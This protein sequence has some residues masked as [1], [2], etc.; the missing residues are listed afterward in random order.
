MPRLR[1][2]PAG[3]TLRNRGF[4]SPEK[5]LAAS[6]ATA[7]L[8]AEYDVARK[9]GQAVMPVILFSRLPLD[10]TSGRGVRYDGAGTLTLIVDSALQQNR[11]RNLSERLLESLISAGLP[12]LAVD[13]HIRGSRS[14]PPAQAPSEHVRTPSIIA[15]AELRD[16]ARTLSNAELREQILA[17]A[18]VLDPLPEE[19]PLAVSTALESTAERLAKLLERAKRLREQLPKAPDPQL[20]PDEAAAAADPELAALR[21]RMRARLARRTIAETE[22]AQTAAAARK[23]LESLRELSDTLLAADPAVPPPDEGTFRAA[24]ERAV[25]A[26]RLVLRLSRRFDAIEERLTLPLEE[27]AGSALSADSPEAAGTD[28]D[29]AEAGT[30]QQMTP[31]E[32]RAKLAKQVK[33]LRKSLQSTQALLLQARIRMPELPDILAADSQLAEEAAQLARKREAGAP[34][35]AL[36]AALSPESSRRLIAWESRLEI[37]QRMDEIEKDL[38][39]AAERFEADRPLLRAPRSRYA[40]EKPETLA[41]LQAI[42]RRLHEE[43]VLLSRLGAESE[44]LSERISI[45]RGDLP[46]V[47]LAGVSPAEKNAQETLERFAARLREL[48]QKLGPRI[49]EAIIPTEAEA[50][51][52]GELSALRAR[53]LARLARYD[54]RAALLAAAR[55]A[56][57]AIGK[58]LTEPRAEGMTERLTELL[59]KALAEAAQ[60]LEAARTAIA[61]EL[62][63]L[64][65]DPDAAQAAPDAAPAAPGAQESEP[66][67]P[68]LFDSMP[69]Q[70]AETE[71]A[72]EAQERDIR[73]NL[74]ALKDIFPIWLDR[75]PREPD[76][77]LIPDEA[78]CAKSET[79]RA[80]RSRMLAR[81]ERRRTLEARLNALK[82]AAS[83]LEERLSNPLSD[84]AENEALAGRLFAEADRFSADAF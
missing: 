52:D 70:D 36:A 19:L 78:A 69:P 68:Q 49:N 25:E 35:E 84:A 42:D 80:V 47:A 81:G 60:K 55:S 75:L 79:L 63:E 56:A 40:D 46:D 13:F 18:K 41:A 72:S 34:T 51:S 23:E 4:R 71:P 6:S 45:L 67:E 44:T 5:S 10:F 61:P 21:R 17:L 32:L 59:R 66:A 73:E 54:E 64:L 39:A 37:T 38:A 30:P 3:F 58:V 11:L 7:A 24:G 14:Q 2:L 53:Q 83:Q 28:A 16:S 65:F 62:A 50:R 48:E 15:A 76:P 8:V 26:S 27:A 9:A 22:T 82:E 20:I 57:E 31:S 1:S 12:I 77:K 29:P 43:E 33:E 74:R